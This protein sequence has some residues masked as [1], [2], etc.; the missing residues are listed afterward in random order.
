[1]AAPLFTREILLTSAAVLGALGL[2]SGYHL[3]RGYVEAL[4]RSLL[5]QGTGREDLPARKVHETIV[6]MSP[7]ESIDLTL[8]RQSLVEVPFVSTFE[9]ATYFEDRED[10]EEPAAEPVLE[11]L[12]ALEK[13]R[14]DYAKSVRDSRASRELRA[15]QSDEAM[16]TSSEIDP[17]ARELI[18]LRSG[19]P[20]RVKAALLRIDASDPVLA[21]FVIRLLAW[22]EVYREALQALRRVAPRVPG[23][24]LDALLDAEQDFAVRR[25]V[26]RALH[27]CPQ[28]RAVDGLLQGLEDVRFEVRFQ[29]GRALAYLLCEHPDHDKLS[30]SPEVVHRALQRETHVDRKVWEGRRLL[31]EQQVHGGKQSGEFSFFDEFVRYRS[32][33]SIEHLFNLLALVE[34][35][36]PLRIAYQGLYTEDPQLRGTA[37]EYL[38]SILPARISAALLPLLEGEHFRHDPGKPKETVLEELLRSQVSIQ[39][40]LRELR[41]RLEREEG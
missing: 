15:K 21:P 26:P 8:T 4:G 28:Q 9:G 31:D 40:N 39:L 38:E 24:L 27:Y 20:T 6:E 23:L 41:E 32:N 3:R 2:L 22:D 11:D 29:C 5:R 13:A 18:E 12:R 34:A 33:R 14:E 19:D 16:K 36:E 10:G 30:V 7:H 17:L 37:L 35:P 1:L 25:R